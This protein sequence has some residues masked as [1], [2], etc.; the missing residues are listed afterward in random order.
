MIITAQ[1][2]GMAKKIEMRDNIAPDF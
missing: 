2:P 1:A